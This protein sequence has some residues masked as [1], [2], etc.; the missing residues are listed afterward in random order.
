MKNLKT[1]RIQNQVQGEHVKSTHDDYITSKYSENWI[2][3]SN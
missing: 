1:A 3:S 2:F